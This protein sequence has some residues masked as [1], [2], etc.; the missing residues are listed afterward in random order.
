M[1]TQQQ[2]EREEQQRIKN[3]VLNYDLRESEDTDGDTAMTPLTR[4][5]NI[6]NTMKAGPE[7]T[8]TYHINRP[9]KQGKDRGGQRVRRL[10]M[11]DLDWYGKTRDNKQATL[12]VESLDGVEASNEVNFPSKRRERS[13]PF[14]ARHRRQAKA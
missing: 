8:T 7:K 6:H 13:V 9:E 12:H 1:K 5:A 3:L 4:N 2:A 14:Q 10:E 11:N